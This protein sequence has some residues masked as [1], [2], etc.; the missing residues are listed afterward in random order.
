MIGSILCKILTDKSNYTSEIDNAE[1]DEATTEI[2]KKSTCKKYIS[3]HKYKNLD[4]FLM[5]ISK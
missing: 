5:D 2:L 3:K 4:E 1:L